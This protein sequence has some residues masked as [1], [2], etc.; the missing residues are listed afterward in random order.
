MGGRPRSVEGD[1]AF[2]EG[3]P[4]AV[5]AEE[6]SSGTSVTDPVALDG[7]PGLPGEAPAAP[8]AV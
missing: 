3:D 4:C 6:P 8:T 5:P 1:P 2:A 7:I